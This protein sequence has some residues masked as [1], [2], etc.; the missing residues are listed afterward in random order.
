MGD[1]C[2]APHERLF[3][4]EDAP[5]VADVTTRAAAYKAS[6]ST[7]QATWVVRV[8]TADRVTGRAVAVVAQQWREPVYLVDPAAR[9]DPAERFVHSDYLTQRDPDAVV[10]ELRRGER[11]GRR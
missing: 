9:L 3:D 1:D 5:T 8:G 10:A 11:P 2:N 7:G 6:I 4:Y